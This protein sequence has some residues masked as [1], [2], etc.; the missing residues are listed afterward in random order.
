MQNLFPGGI[1]AKDYQEAFRICEQLGPDFL[2]SMRQQI[3]YWRA[4]QKLY[5][6]CG[7]G[8][9]AGFDGECFDRRRV[10]WIAAW[11]DVDRERLDYGLR[12]PLPETEQQALPSEEAERR[13]DTF[14]KESAGENAI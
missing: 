13:Y 11:K 14:L 9:T 3:N 1:H 8:S 5:R 6:D 12:L 4:L 10:E 7:W 2:R